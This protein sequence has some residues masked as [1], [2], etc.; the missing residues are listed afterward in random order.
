MSKPLKN[1]RKRK[2]ESEAIESKP[3]AAKK[4]KS[5][6]LKQN[7]DDTETDMG[8]LFSS[9][10][11]ENK[12]SSSSRS[13]G[14]HSYPSISSRGTSP[15]GHSQTSAPESHTLQPKVS[16]EFWDETDVLS[17]ISHVPFNIC[18]NFVNLI[19]EGSTLP[20]I[21]R[22]R[23]GVMGNMQPTEL[24]EL[25]VTYENVCQLKKK[26]KSV[27]A[28]L[29]KSKKLTPDIQRSIV[30]AKSLPEL[31]LV[32]APLKT[33]A[34]TLADK[35]RSLGLEPAAKSLLVGLHV[36]LYSLCNVGVEELKTVNQVETQIVYIVADII[37]KDPKVVEY[38]RK[39]KEE[40]V[41]SLESKLSRNA[42][43]TVKEEKSSGKNDPE[44]YKI[45]FD[46]RC[47]AS[48]LKAHQILA[49]NR[50]E[51][52]KVLS[53]QVIVP[54]WF[55]NKLERFCMTLWKGSNYL[56]KALT[57]AYG[58]LI[59][60]WLSRQVRHDL[61]AYAEKEAIK[62]FVT[63]LEKFLLTEPVR[64]CNILGLDPGFRAGCKVGV[65]AAD[66]RMLE[67]STLY[68]KFNAA[69][70]IEANKLKNLIS[71]HNC[72]VIGLGNGTAC[73]ETE[74]WLKRH[75]IA[76]GIPIIIVPEQGASV[77]SISKEAIKEHPNMDCN[78]ISALSI[79][80]RVLDPMG[81]L[82][83]VEPKHLGVGLY[84]HDIT[85][86]LLDSALEH[87]VEKVVSLA[88]V[89]VNT[90]SQAL[91]R[92]ISGLSDAKAKAVVSYREKSN[93]FRT[94][95]ELLKV[96]GIGK[97]TFEQCAGF[98]KVVGGP[99]P[100]DN[101]IVHPES[102]EIARKFAS[103]LS[104]NIRDI[105]KPS[106][107]DKEGAKLSQV[108]IRGMSELLGTDE[109]TLEL[110][111]NAFKQ[112]P[113]EDIVKFSKPVYSAA[114]QDSSQVK[115]GMTVTGVVR[116]VVPFGCFVDCGIG[117]DGLIHS[118]NMGPNPF[119]QI[120]DRVSVTLLASPKPKRIQLKLEHIIH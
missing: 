115:V 14:Y 97:V 105:H 60:P 58:R 10:K 3:K 95:A 63:N 15:L 73:R 102:Y 18:K 84:Q 5:S 82:V 80:R 34:V 114:V 49:I 66:G 44:T 45:Y 57:D 101:T 31:E 59:K 76:D 6:K 69:I 62:T 81:E 110:I 99:E 51:D 83:K 20:F 112:I 30:N 91:L 12:T 11:D 92:R 70:D 61:T 78:L 117:D 85:P 68:P 79:A 1:T 38:M 19:L 4:S 106:F 22:Y 53:V 67:V 93:G 94:R 77:Y 47:R 72:E 104:I 87:T 100:L 120:G 107:L 52:V 108:D 46:F 113:H 40:T 16:T 42:N 29:E 54:D 90:A 32:Y 111:V 75:N 8:G 71:K 17:E 98:L 56:K 2:A 74:S 86:K 35:A 65:I 50:G 89:D 13:Q 48:Y 103:K 41:F 109:S 23:K 26:T 64:G 25:F 9:N 118:K 55:Y 24:Q 7:L 21:A 36:D 119:P 37:Y 27:L 88:G 39:L 116:N 28:T 43:K 96:G 33:R